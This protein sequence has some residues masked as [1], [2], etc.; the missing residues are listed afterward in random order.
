MIK[1]RGKFFTFIFSLIPGAGHMYLGFMKLG[2]SIMTV[3]FALLFISSWLRVGPILYI[4]PIL[5]FYSFFDAMNKVSLSD[6][7]FYSLDDKYLLISD[8]SVSDTKFYRK[9]KLYIGIALIVFGAYII[10]LNIW[11]NVSVFF[12][13]VFYSFIDKITYLLPQLGVGVL[14]I[15]IGLRLVSGKRKDEES[16]NE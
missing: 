5:W 8:F 14:I 7:E 6:E 16:G 4:L 11:N 2:L 13:G 9:N 15:Y 10:W 3:L 1:K 12:H